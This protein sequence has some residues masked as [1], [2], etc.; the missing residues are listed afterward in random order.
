MGLIKRDRTISLSIEKDVTNFRDFKEPLRW[1]FHHSCGY[2]GAWE[3]QAGGKASFGVEHFIPKSFDESRICD[4]LNLLFACN[5]CN[6]RKW[7]SHPIDPEGRGRDFLDPCSVDYKEHF[8]A[9]SDDKLIGL[10]SAANHM[11]HKLRLN[12]HKAVIYRRNRRLVLHAINEIHQ[13]RK[14]INALY[15]IRKPAIQK[16]KILASDVGQLLKAKEEL[17]SMLLP[18]KLD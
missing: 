18:R 9:T 16:A 7:K 13:L 10:S 4:P 1:D 14:R 8:K 3:R 17:V 2:C 6:R 15:S 12:I 5:A 11:I